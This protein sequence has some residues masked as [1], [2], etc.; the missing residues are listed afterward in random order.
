MNN[1]RKTVAWV[2]A[3]VLAVTLSLLYTFLYIN[4]QQSCFAFG[5]AGSLLFVLLTFN[6]RIY[7]ESFLHVFYAAMG[8]FGFLNWGGS[9]VQTYYQPSTHAIAIAVCALL[10]VVLARL[11]PALTNSEEPWLDAFT[12]VFSLWA[13][14]MMVNFVH[15]NWLYWIVIDTVAV[16]LYVRRKLYI[17]ALLFVLY[18]AMAISAYFELNFFQW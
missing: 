14:W 15:E 3:E 17:G 6:K 7:A 18:T 9:I 4:E 2:G 10:V 8:V 11:L 12:T 13:T 5:I 16:V 1:S